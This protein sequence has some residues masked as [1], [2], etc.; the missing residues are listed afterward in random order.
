MKRIDT[1]FGIVILAG[2]AMPAPIHAQLH[3]EAPGVP[4][5]PPVDEEP[6]APREVLPAPEVPDKM[7]IPAPTVRDKMSKVPPKK[8]AMGPG[9]TRTIPKKERK[10]VTPGPP[11]H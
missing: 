2:L 6:D 5:V 1:L 10:E 8:P 11:A 7:A 9:G 4:T 3:P